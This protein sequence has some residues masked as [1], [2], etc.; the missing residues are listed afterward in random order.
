MI[1]KFWCF[2][3]GH[4]VTGKDYDHDKG[5]HF[6]YIIRLTHCTRCG[7]NLQPKKDQSDDD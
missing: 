6:Y 2:I 3:W 4:K 5:S 7:K 1:K